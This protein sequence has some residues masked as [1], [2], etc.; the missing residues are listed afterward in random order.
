VIILH[1]EPPEEGANTPPQIIDANDYD[2]LAREG[3]PQPEE[4]LQVSSSFVTTYST[5]FELC[6]VMMQDSSNQLLEEDRDL[7]AKVRLHGSGHAF[8]SLQLLVWPW[9]HH[10]GM[11]TRLMIEVGESHQHH[12]KPKP[13]SN[14]LTQAG[15]MQINRCGVS[16]QGHW[17][18]YLGILLITL[19]PQQLRSLEQ[20]NA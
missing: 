11:H 5:T 7:W 4:A 8:T 20:L 16:Q 17:S 1:A 12:T 6:T 13:P 9:A 19:L 18:S 2:K 14:A 15:P 3:T 10:L